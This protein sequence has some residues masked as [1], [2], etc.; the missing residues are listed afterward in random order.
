MMK[1]HITLVFIMTALV[2]W[3]Q[4]PTHIK[5]HDDKVKDSIWSDPLY[6]TLMVVGLVVLY[7]VFRASLKIIKKS[8]SYNDENKKDPSS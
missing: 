7:L 2:N 4:T 5:T 1:F 6:I 8:Q 3:A